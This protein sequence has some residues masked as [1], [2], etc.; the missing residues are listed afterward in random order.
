MAKFTGAVDQAPQLSIFYVVL[1]KLRLHTKNQPN[2][3]A[4]RPSLG[5]YV[6]DLAPNIVIKQSPL[7]DRYISQNME[8]IPK[9]VTFF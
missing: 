1:V 6:P 9:Y 8:G 7:N 5:L 2:N 3:M 4:R